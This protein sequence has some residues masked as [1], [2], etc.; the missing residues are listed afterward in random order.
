MENDNI[1]VFTEIVRCGIIGK[2]AFQTFHKFHNRK[3]HI[4]GRKEDFTYIDQHPNNVYH[5]LDD[6]P[7]ILNSFNSGHRGTSMVW[8]KV[9]LEQPEKY[10]IHIDSDVVFRGDA[11]E[12]VARK[13]VEGYDVVGSIRN[14]PNNPHKHRDDVRYLPDVTA[15]YCFGFNRTKIFVKE[16]HLLARLVENSLDTPTVHELMRL[17]PNRYFY[18]PT[19]DYFDPV[20]FLI[21]GEG[22]KV[23]ILDKDVMGGF[24]EN[25][26]KVNK[27]GTLNK[28]CDFGDKIVHFASVGSGLNFL[29]M[30]GRGEHINVPEWYVDYGL[31]KLDLYMRLF[32]N[33]KIMPDEKS[34]FLHFEPEFREAFKGLNL[35]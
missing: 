28:D 25:G 13:L 34:Q 14:Y 15:T 21:L 1:Y 20:A 26:G 10:I 17:Y 31:S 11:V 2:I 22:G 23:F 18:N 16:F 27:Y 32:Y 30:K 33:T 7:E 9:I 24:D 5:Y 6:Q 3:L 29:Q 8:T 12:E 4:Y 35:S 19:L